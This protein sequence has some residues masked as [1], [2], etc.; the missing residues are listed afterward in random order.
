MTKKAIHIGDTV[1]VKPSK[2]AP[3]IRARVTDIA[4]YTDT[5]LVCWNMI[6]ED[7]LSGGGPFRWGVDIKPC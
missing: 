6:C 4:I 5:G 1:M 3:W 2:A 7:G